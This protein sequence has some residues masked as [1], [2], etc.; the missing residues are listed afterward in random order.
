MC[1]NYWA[2]DEMEKVV[3]KWVEYVVKGVKDLQSENQN[4]FMKF[5]A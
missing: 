5:I 3:D 2:R 4:L 1:I